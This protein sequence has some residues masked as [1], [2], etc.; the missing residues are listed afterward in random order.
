MED[1]E[2]GLSVVESGKKSVMKDLSIQE[3]PMTGIIVADLRRENSKVRQI[4]LEQT[5]GSIADQ[6]VGN[7]ECYLVC[8]K[9]WNVHR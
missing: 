2:H 5:R 4:Q 9:G 6:S 7:H 3:T 1:N 8:S